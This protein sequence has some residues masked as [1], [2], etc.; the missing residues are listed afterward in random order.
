MIVLRPLTEADLDEVAALE[1]E[2]F[3]PQAWSRD[4]LAEEL[5]APGRRYVAALDGEQV[6]GYAGILLAEDANVMTVGVVGSHRRRGIGTA[7]LDALLE[8]ARQERS[9]RVFLEV[10]AD[11]A[12]AQALYERAGFRSMGLRR[13]Y[14]QPGGHDAC[15]M[16]LDLRRPPGPLG[17]QATAGTA[18][19]G[20]ERARDPGGAS[21]SGGTVSAG[22]TGPAQPPA[23]SR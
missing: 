1:I 15:V 13:G 23:S 22:Q 6:V 11:D 16:A 14:Y 5:E 9:R 10:R 7:M 4:A 19:D 12:G 8:A 3:G 21:S 2:L 18:A 20:S 17:S